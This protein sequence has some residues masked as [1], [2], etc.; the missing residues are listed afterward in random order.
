M[1]VTHPVYGSKNI[2]PEY[3]D[4]FVANGWEVV[5]SASQIEAEIRA[6]ITAK[7]MAE[8]DQEEDCG[9]NKMMPEP[10]TKQRGRP[11]KG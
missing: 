7:V 1:L 6:E 8:K 10:E 9:C 3:K 2:D 4:K 11:R 5:R